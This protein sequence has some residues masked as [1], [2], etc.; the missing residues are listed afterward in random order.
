MQIDLFITAF[1]TLF[2]VI[3]PIGVT[4]LFVALTQGNNPKERRNISLRANAIALFILLI[5]TITGDSILRSIGVGIPAFRI[6]GGLLLF[7]IA[8]EMLFER[9]TERRDKQAEVDDGP[10]PSVFPLA[11]PLLAGPGAIASIVLMTGSG[12]GWSATLS[13]GAAVLSVLFIALILFQFASPIERLF[14]KT[15]INVIT[16][17]MGMLLAALSVQFVIDGFVDLGVLS[18]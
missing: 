9:R 11:T 8:V 14:G 6:A 13:V 2:V 18:L 12:G 3:D 5:F 7:L 4:P 1:F 10:D 17:I 15:G 16:R